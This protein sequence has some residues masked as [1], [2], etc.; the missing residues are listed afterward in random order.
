M[1]RTPARQWLRERLPKLLFWAA[2]AF[3]FVMAVMPHPLQLPGSPSDK[4]EHIVAFLT[5]AGLSAWA[6]PRSS[7]VRLL[8]GLSLFGAAIELVQAIPALHRDSDVV[9]WLADTVAAAAMLTALYWYRERSQSG[10][11]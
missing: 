10:S 5:L 4:V 3:T 1:M 8:V 7:R 6:Y 11:T 2:S 9:D